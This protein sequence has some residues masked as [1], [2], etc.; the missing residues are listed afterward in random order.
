M[1]LTSQCLRQVGTQAMKTHKGLDV[2]DHI[3]TATALGR[4]RM[5]SPMPGYVYPGKAPGTHLI[6]G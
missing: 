1:V 2:R 5:A 4:G 6:G 3:Y